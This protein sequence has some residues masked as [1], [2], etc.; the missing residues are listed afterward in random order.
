MNKSILN[1]KI[2]ENIKHIDNYGNEYWEAREL[3]KVL[4][5]KEWR[6]FL[7]VLDKAKESCK[8]S[9]FNLSEQLVEFNKLSKRNNNATV[10]IQD[11]KLS[12]YICYLIVQNADPSKE[13][14]AL[15]QTYFAIQTRKQ[16]LRELE[17]DKLSEEEKRLYQRNRIRKWNHTLNKTALNA[18]VKNF[19]KFHNAGYRG[20]YN[21]ETADDIAKRKKLRYRE[22]ILDNMGSDE[23]ASNLFRVSLTNQKLI[24]ESIYGEKKAS[25]A[26][27]VVGSAVRDTIKK[28]G[29]TLPEKLSTPNVSLKTIE[30]Y[31][32]NNIDKE[33]I[34]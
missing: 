29:G 19:D 22:D 26:H 9:N 8:N 32:K 17:Y 18:G 2:F 23:L 31:N 4:E 11:Y 34:K 27:Y 25:N 7:K 1:A 3:Q 20:L 33:E 15:G 6:N 14:I 10:S 24:N 30:K 21:G 16:E 12:R 13:I 5:Y 28:V